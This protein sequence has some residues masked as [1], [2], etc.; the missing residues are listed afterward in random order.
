MAAVAPPSPSV[1]IGAPRPPPSSGGGRR[2]SGGAS[3]VHARLAAL[4]RGQ[5]PLRRALARLAARFVAVQGWEPLGYVRLRDWAVERVGLSARML[6]ELARMDAIFAELPRLETA[7]LRGEVSWAKARLVGRVARAED[8]GRWLELA[9]RLRVR[10]LEREVRAVDVGSLEAGAAGLGEGVERDEEGAPVETREGVVI[11]CSPLARHKWWRARQVASRMAGEALPPWAAMEAVAAEVASAIPVEA[12]DAGGGGDGEEPGVFSVAWVRPDAASSGIPHG[13]RSDSSFARVGA[14]R[15]RVVAGPLPANGCAAQ[16]YAER[17]AAEL[18]PEV[19]DLLRGVDELDAFELDA[20]IRRAVAR[21]QRFESAAGPLLLA[22]ANGRLHR[23]HG[24][25]SL[26]DLARDLLGVSPRKAR[27]LVR[28]ERACSKAPALRDAYRDGGLSWVRAQALV[29]LALPPGVPLA[30]WVAWARRV[31]VRRLEEDVG[32]ALALRELAPPPERQTGAQ[33]TDRAAAVEDDD[34]ETVRL[35]WSAPRPAARFFRAVLC[36]LQRSIGRT[37][38]RLPTPGEGFE[39]MLDH[40]L[41]TWSAANARERRRHGVIAR[42]GYRCMVPACS[43]YRNLHD[44]HLRFRSAGGSNALVN[45]TTLC[46]AHHLRGVHAGRVRI[47][48]EAPDGLRFELGLRPGR[49]PV[50]VYRSR[51]VLERPIREEIRR[52]EEGRWTA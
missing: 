39:A 52:S 24:Y 1:S 44:H 35:F 49:P 16:E 18:P 37:T 2:A 45:R 19:W 51:D 30:D 22:A 33:D 26:E 13:A 9:R 27:G 4:A 5:A 14:A 31:T 11:A 17:R 29:P 10:A 34:A 32:R 8:E 38:A 47:T 20:R 12:A 43:S 48:G 40:A 21:E 23:A 15:P 42:D 25:A 6:Q 28:L 50:E 41:E 46:A 3:R 36:S 7:F